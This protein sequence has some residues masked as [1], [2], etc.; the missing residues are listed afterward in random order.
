MITYSLVN[1]IEDIRTLWN[2]ELG[3]IYPI[4]GDVFNQNVILYP[5]KY[6]LG[7]FDKDKLVG[8][9][10]GKKN[11]TDIVSYVDMGW[12]SLIFVSKKY[13]KQGIGSHLLEEVE[14]YLD[15]KTIN[16]GKDIN[17]FFPGVPCDFDWVTDTFFIKRGYTDG[18]YT[19]DVININPQK[20]Q[21]RNKQYQFK[22]CTLNEK[23]AL[24]AHMRDNFPGRWFYDV[25][26]YF[27]DGGKGD[28]YVICLDGN[29]VIGFARINDR[30]FKHISYNITWYQRFNNLGG[31][32]PLGVDSAYRGQDIGFDIVAFGINT[33][34]ERKISEIL[35]DW[36]SILAFYRQFGFEVWKSFKFLSKKG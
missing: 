24:L 15:V 18:G 35:I 5:Q 26:D 3:F 17:N 4:A 22:V 23:E 7:A 8:F 30:K 6:V 31:I 33:L 11:I 25:D 34:L 20:I 27:K 9:I 1:N 36:T 16:V 32:G 12:I 28:E 19:H 2:S 21:L 14:K 29:K 10:V 13:R